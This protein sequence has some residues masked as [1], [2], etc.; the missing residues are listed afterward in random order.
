MAKPVPRLS[1][2]EIQRVIATAWDDRPPFDAVL[3]QHGLN[4]GQVVQLLKREL[5]PNAFKVWTART[6]GAALPGQSGGPGAP[7]RPARK[8]PR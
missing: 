8:P 5:T 1:P 7:R 4:P 6:R 3:R 2:E